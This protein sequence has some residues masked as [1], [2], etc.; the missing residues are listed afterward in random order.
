MELESIYK[1]EKISSNRRY[2]GQRQELLKNLPHE[3][4]L[5]T[6]DKSKRFCE[7]CGKALH[8]V[9]EEFIR[10]EVIFIPTKISAID[11]YRETFE[12]R[13]CRKEGKQHMKKSPIPYPV[14][15]HSYASASMIVWLIHQKYEMSISFY[16]QE[17]EWKALGIKMN[18]TTMANWIKVSYRDWLFPIVEKLQQNYFIFSDYNDKKYCVISYDDTETSIGV[19]LLLSIARINGLNTMKYLYFILNGIPGTAFL[20]YPEYLEDYMPW[21]SSIQ[22]TCR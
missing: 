12:C 19:Y 16:S 9:G 7:I 20:E 14:I 11:Y 18:R 1:K 22:R 8:S 2:K 4:K 21:N 6:L 3:K 15:Q 13:N 17:K 5:C 10:T